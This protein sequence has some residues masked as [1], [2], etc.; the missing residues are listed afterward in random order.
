MRP[1]A[2]ALLGPRIAGYQPCALHGTDA[3]NW[4]SEGHGNRWTSVAAKQLADPHLPT[5]T[6][7]EPAS[8][9]PSSPGASC[10]S[11]VGDVVHP[12]RAVEDLEADHVAVAR[13]V[14]LRRALHQV[15]CVGREREQAVRQGSVQRLDAV[16]LSTL[17]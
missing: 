7:Q 16:F 17:Y 2:A 14:Q 8:L 1:L 6:A 3:R 10:R 5:S 11:P 9:P 13:I 4:G 12:Q 15:L